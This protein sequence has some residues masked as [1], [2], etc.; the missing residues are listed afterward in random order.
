[1]VPLLSR[2]SSL[3][4]IALA[5][6]SL[7]GCQGLSGNSQ[8]KI[9]TLSASPASIN[10]GNVAVG[11]KATKSETVT[12]TGGAAVT[13]SQANVTGTGFSLGPFALPTTLNPSQSVTV[14]VMFAPSAAGAA[15][16]TLSMVSD[17]SNSPLNISLSG[18]GMTQ[19]QLSVAPTKL[20]FGNV[21]VGT[22]S[23]L[24]AS[25]SAS[26]GTVT[27]SAASS[28]SAEYALSGM[29]LPATVADGQS[30][31]FTVTFTPSASGASPATLTFTSTASNSPTT[32]TLAGNGQNPPAHWVDLTWN[33]TSGA[34]SY[35]V[36]R[37]LAK[38]PSYSEISSGDATTAYRDNNVAAGK[39]YDYVVTA[40]DGSGHESGYSNPA[41]V[42]I[43]AP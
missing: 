7:A 16:G 8:S 19:G 32:E 3:L 31:P 4:F 22:S 38:D 41:E 28:S 2:H 6:F 9:G 39:T 15:N 13:I 24:T 10:A 18:V 30:V 17:A 29:A 34:V 12:N 26:G 35:N 23:S 5:T 43:P 14:T 27:V 37:K 42:T 36:Y 20:N 33:S 40:V 21:A 25:L 1:V 11:D